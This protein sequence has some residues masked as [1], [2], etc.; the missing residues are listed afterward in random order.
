MTIICPEKTTSTVHLQQP[1]NMLRLSSACSAISNYFHLASHYE[2]HSIVMNVSLHTANIN[3][4]NISNLG[5]RIW[6]HFSRNWTQ[7]YLQNLRNVPEVWVAQVYRDMI[8][9]SAPIHSFTIKDDDKDSSLKWT[10]LKHPG[11]YIETISMIFVLCI[12][13][14]CLDPGSGLPPL[15]TSLSPHSLC[16]MP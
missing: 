14:Y 7:P 2:D 1:F 5:F 8:N 9:A 16:N 13:V 6:Q 4:I 3:T 10:I 12:C 15:S 11:T